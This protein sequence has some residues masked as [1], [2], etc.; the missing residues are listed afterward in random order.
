MTVDGA[1]EF[2]AEQPQV[3]HALTVLQEVGLGYLRLG[4]PATEL[5]GGEA[6]RI[7]LATELQRN[8]RGN[9]LY[10]LDEPTTGL[11]PSDVQRLVAQLDGLVELG[12]TVIVVEHDLDVVAA[13]DYVIDMGPGAGEAGGAVVAY[14]TPAEVAT[15]RARAELL[16]ISNAASELAITRNAAYRKSPVSCD[17]IPSFQRSERDRPAG[18]FDRRYTVLP[19]LSRRAT[20]D[21]KGSRRKLQGPGPLL[22]PSPRWKRIRQP[23]PSE[24]PATIPNGGESRCQPILAPGGYSV[25]SDSDRAASECPATVAARARSGS[26]ESGNRTPASSP[27]NPLEIVE[28]KANDPPLGLNAMHAK[29]PERKLFD[30]IKEGGFFYRR[31]DFRLEQEAVGAAFQG[32]E[33][34]ADGWGPWTHSLDSFALAT[35]GLDRLGHS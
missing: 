26:R 30:Y 33:L 20:H 15:V 2:F 35:D 24:M 3:S 29:V 18:C 34:S 9:T 14:G 21:V 32:K 22:C 25:T 10:V 27:L 13:S 1:S 11:H 28:T 16:F 8:Q 12:N 5:S 4:Q 6:Q 23:P 17:S 7:K 19:F 31:H